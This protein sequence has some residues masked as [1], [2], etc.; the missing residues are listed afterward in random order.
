MYDNAEISRSYILNDNKNRAGIYLWLH[1]LSGNLYIGSSFDISRRFYQY[2]SKANLK[3]KKTMYINNALYIHG[4]SQFSFF[5][6]KYIDIKDLPLKEALKLLLSFEQNFI[7]QINPKY[8]MLKVA[9]SPI[10]YKHSEDTKALMS[11]AHLGKI[12]SIE[13]I[14]KMKITHSNIDRT[15]KNNPMFGKTGEN[16]PMFGRT[17]SIETLAKMSLAKNKRVY[18]YTKDSV[19][20]ELIL[21]KSFENYSEVIKYFDFSKRTLSRYLNK[22]KLYKNNW[23][24]STSKLHN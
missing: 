17:H 15:G 5:I 9:G 20:N 12:H 22:N 18:I 13:T 11:K 24:L 23:I 16:H 4:H 6:L 7:N 19:S 21:F 8:N 2:S 1:K 14:T 10:G 3:R